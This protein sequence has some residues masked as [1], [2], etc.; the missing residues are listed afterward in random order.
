[1]G[2]TIFGVNKI[3]DDFV[4]AGRRED[5]VGSVGDIDRIAENIERG[6]P[7]ALESGD[8]PFDGADR[9]IWRKPAL[10]FLQKFLES[11]NRS[12]SPFVFGGKHRRLIDE[13]REQDGERKDLFFPLRDE[14]FPSGEFGEPL[15]EIRPH[16]LSGDRRLHPVEE[17]GV[18]HVVNDCEGGQIGGNGGLEIVGY[19][20]EKRALKMD[21]GV[22]VEIRVEIESKESV[23]VQNVGRKFRMN[24]SFVRT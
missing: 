5:V 4:K 16:V 24:A 2:Q 9:M 3:V 11:E 21:P 19:C 10:H 1:M 22:L 15:R 6:E 13:L 12:A 23:D 18:E 20:V 14:L 7:H 8:A 17:K